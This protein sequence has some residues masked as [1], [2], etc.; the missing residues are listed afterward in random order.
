MVS[1]IMLIGVTSYELSAKSP[2]GGSLAYD[3][4]YLFGKVVI[5]GAIIAGVVML[6]RSIRK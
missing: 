4:G 1:A 3:L 6:I 5:Y 2:G